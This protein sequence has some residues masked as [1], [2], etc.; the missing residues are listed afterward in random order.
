MPASKPL[1]DLALGDSLAVGTGASTVGSRYVDVLY[2]HELARF[3]TLQLD[4]LG[5]GGATTTSVING[6]G[7]SYTTGTQL[8]DD[9]A[10]LRAH[11]KQVAMVTSDIGANNVD[12]CLN[13]STINAAC[14]Q[15]GLGKIVGDL[16]QILSGLQ[17]AAPG[18]AVY[19]MNYYDPFLGEWLAGSTGQSLATGSVALLTQLN[20]QLTQVYTAGGAPTTDVATAFQSTDFALIGSYLGVTEPRN[21]ADACNWTLFC[22]GGGNIHANDIG[23]GIA[24]STTPPPA[25]T[26]GQVSTGR[27]TAVGGHLSRH[28]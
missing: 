16:P 6:P 25:A 22:S 11:L 27:L 24:V 12:G 23:H 5:C 17:A 13:G 15:S 2:Q 14:I 21:V 8:G 20:D 1:Y 26:V 28:L 4:N 9:E 19:G 18:V 10:F 7:C 3:P